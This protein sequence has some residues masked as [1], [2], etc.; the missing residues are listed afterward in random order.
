M[1]ASTDTLPTADML[2]TLTVN[3]WSSYVIGKPYIFS[4][5]FFL[6]SFFFL[7]LA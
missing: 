5:C 7:F 3:L 2:L 6:S 1:C 4:C